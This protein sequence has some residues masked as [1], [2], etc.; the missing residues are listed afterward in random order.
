MNA[1]HHDAI[2]AAGGHA[3]GYRPDIDG[4][5]AVAVLVVML[6]HLD[7]SWMP[8]GFLGVDVFF[9]ISGFVVTSS[10]AR[11]AVKPSGEREGVFLSFY[12]R[13]A[14]RLMPA[15]L[16]MIAL[17]T[18]CMTIIIPP[19]SSYMFRYF[20]SA[21]LALL[22][23]SNIE[24]ASLKQ[25]YFDE[26]AKT[27]E[28]N[29]F[30][31][32][33]SLCVEEQFYFLFPAILMTAYG[34][35][36]EMLSTARQQ[37]Q[38]RAIFVFFVVSACSLLAAW[39]LP[40]EVGFYILPSR[41]W[42]LASGALLFELLS[43]AAFL[44]SSIG[45]LSKRVVSFALQLLAFVLMGYSFLLTPRAD[46][47]SLPVTLPAVCAALF[48]IA[49]GSLPNAFLNISLS[50]P[51]VVYI[52]KI[53]YPL[54]LFHWPI[55]VLCTWA[56]GLKSVQN[57]L[58]CLAASLMVAAFTYHVIESPFRKWLPS[59]S[60]IVLPA[61]GV[62][63]FCLY[64][65]LH[66]LEGPLRNTFWIMPDF[67]AQPHPLSHSSQ[68]VQN[69]AVSQNVTECSCRLAEPTWHT[70]PCAVLGADGKDLAPCFVE[71][72]TEVLV[73]SRWIPASLRHNCFDGSCMVTRSSAA[74]STLY[75]L[76]DS[77]ASKFRYGL[78]KAVFGSFIVK[79]LTNTGCSYGPPSGGSLDE[80]ERNTKKATAAVVN[81]LRKGDIIA[82]SNLW[83]HREHE[84]HW[85]DGF[86]SMLD[87]LH[88]AASSRG[89][90]ILL[91]GPKADLPD[92]G[93]SCV[94]TLFHR[95]VTG[96]CELP[97]QKAREVISPVLQTLKKF[98]EGRPAIALFEY[99]D[100][101]CD[102]R[103][104]GAFVPGTKTL[105]FYD[106][107]HLTEAGSLYLA[108]YISYFLNSHDMFPRKDFPASAMQA[109]RH[110]GR[111]LRRSN[112]NL[113]SR[114]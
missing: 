13:R 107:I 97:V 99:Q 90:K 75:L 53:S 71:V 38:I 57:K 48:F 114:A 45:P 14:K 2:T 40:S 104:C 26:G 15:N 19:W 80:C 83:T 77:T 69:I 42:E 101:L 33:W 93:Q 17:A 100:V 32:T 21:R 91:I 46:G 55:M 30:T 98:T 10:L 4:L 110:K 61:M 28:R 103:T 89:A 66:V 43:S 3:D 79:R 59:R 85:M 51:P 92:Q 87:S 23:L 50:N 20:S 12:A 58:A 29:P 111:R 31:H 18:L 84:N 86:F 27:L 94:P 105:Q 60:L 82:I 106:T 102:D 34:S 96:K 109:G 65:W 108:P 78:E 37:L 113:L 1:A 74:P 5:R 16:F 6:Y 8:G 44:D 76:G 7:K 73:E 47:F 88:A 36:L 9:V 67:P 39:K 54:Y 35:S 68:L 22:S 41:L 72:P 63:I 70:P 24:F 49:A 25:N 52:G 62:G 56:F 11:Y 95:N 81:N 64:C 112:I